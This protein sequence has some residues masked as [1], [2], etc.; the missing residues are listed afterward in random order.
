MIT[1]ERKGDLVW[2]RGSLDLNE[3]HSVPEDHRPLYDEALLQGFEDHP[4]SFKIRL[5]HVDRTGVVSSWNAEAPVTISGVYP[6][7]RAEVAE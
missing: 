4:D 1:T 2:I 5:I 7:K 3:K 6:A